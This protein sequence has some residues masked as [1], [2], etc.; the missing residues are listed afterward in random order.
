MATNL[1]PTMARGI[2]LPPAYEITSSPTTHAQPPPPTYTAGPT[3]T[4][5]APPR[6][7][8][9]PPLSRTPSTTSLTSAVSQ[10]T[11]PLPIYTAQP[12]TEPHTLSRSLFHWGFLCP[13]LWVIGVAILWIDLKA[14]EVG[15]FEQ[16]VGGGGGGGGSA[17]GRDGRGRRERV[18]REETVEERVKRERERL[19]LDETI[20]IMRKVRTHATRFYTFSSS[21]SI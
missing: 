14:E 18:E 6:I 1:Q 9:T 4:A 8:I 20:G 11:T 12:T 17:N 19:V 15:G 21:H 7:I 16:E 3:A 5:S 10:T 2:T 13:L